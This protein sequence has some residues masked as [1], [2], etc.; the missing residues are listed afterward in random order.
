MQLEVRITSCEKEVH[1][2][3]LYFKKVLLR[4]L[5]SLK[6]YILKCELTKQYSNVLDA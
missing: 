3:T 2:S 6:I 5:Y 4:K 1:F